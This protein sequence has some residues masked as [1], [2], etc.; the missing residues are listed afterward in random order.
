MLVKSF[1]LAISGFSC[2]TGRAVAL[3]SGAFVVEHKPV[4]SLRYKAAEGMAFLAAQSV[5]SRVVLFAAQIVIGWLFTPEEFGIVG[6]ALTVTTVAWTFVGFGVD[7]VLQQ[8][9]S[10]LPFWE[11]AAFTVSMGQGLLTALALAVAAPFCARA[12]G[13]PAIVG[14]LLLVAASMPIITVSVVPGAKIFAGLNFRWAAGYTLVE[15]V[16]NQ[17]L[18]IIFAL[19]HFGVYAFFIPIPLVFALRALVYLRKMPLALRGRVKLKQIQYFLK[20]GS[21][22]QLSKLILALIDQGDY[23]LLGLFATAEAVGYYFFAF[24]IAAMPVRVVAGTL[25]SILFSTLTQ[26]GSDKRRM[27]DAAFKSAEALSYVVTPLCFIQAAVADPVL[28]SLFGDKW[29][30]SILLLQI[31]SLGLPAEAMATVAR[32]HLTAIGAFDS[33]LKF[34]FVSGVF[35]LVVV[36]IGAHEAQAVGVAMAVFAYYV[37]LQPILFFRVFPPGERWFQHLLHIFLMPAI[38]SAVSVL[39]GTGAS[40]LSQVQNPLLQAMIIGCVSSLAYAAQLRLVQ[41]GMFDELWS[42]CRQIVR[43]NTRS[44]SDQ[45]I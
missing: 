8:R 33:F 21:R 40:L 34:S 38:I 27:V 5:A 18:I 43:V 29:L 32:A 24:R 23:L 20:Q 17:A 39:C 15:L 12:F 42:L 37:I 10:K 6:V 35:F 13:Q 30:P 25:Q 26:F 41:R 28:R 22:V 44:A 7:T 11:K 2:A 4:K 14:P 36:G 3:V 16:A 45:K 9:S 19:L 1:D 31:L